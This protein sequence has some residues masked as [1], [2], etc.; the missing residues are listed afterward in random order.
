MLVLVKAI[1]LILKHTHS[2]NHQH[3]IFIIMS[4]LLPTTPQEIGPVSS[5]NLIKAIEELG[6]SNGYIE[7]L[8]RTSSVDPITKPLSLLSFSNSLSTITGSATH[9]NCSIRLRGGF[10]PGML[11]GE[12]E[13]H[14]KTEKG[15]S[16]N[17]KYKTQIRAWLTEGNGVTDLQGNI[18]LF[19]SWEEILKGSINFI[20]TAA[21]GQGA[22]VVFRR[23][24]LPVAEI[25][26]DFP[27]ATG[28]QCGS[29]T[30]EGVCQWDE[31][32]F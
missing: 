31:I 28:Y 10:V 15:A 6:G 23:D 5:L 7:H 12:I 11:F 32:V 25:S 13:V 20:I 9:H 19:A 3:S 21:E 30:C 18:V 2:T 8:K 26:A 17:V 1:N 22:H 27:E 14:E 4:V 24:Y 29:F 16:L